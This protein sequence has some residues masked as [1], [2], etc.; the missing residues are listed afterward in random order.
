M[1][2]L[3]LLVLKTSLV[4]GVACAAAS[5]L[6][7]RSAALRHFMLAAGLLCAA[8]IPALQLLTPAWTLPD[9]WSRSH[10]VSSP[11]VALA[12]PVAP[13]SALNEVATASHPPGTSVS[14]T[15]WLVAAWVSGTLVALGVLLAGL[16]RVRRAVTQTVP[17][18]E[19][20]WLEAA[21]RIS[22]RFATRP[23]VLLEGSDPAVLVTH[24]WW[25]PTI[26]LPPGCR[27]WPEDKLRSVLLHELAHVRRRDWVVQ[28]G[29]EVARCV[30]WFNP[31]F[32]LAARRLRQES[33]RACDDAVLREGVDAASYASHLLEIARAVRHARTLP[34]ALGM[35][36]STSLEGRV[37]AMFDERFDRRPV[38]LRA[39]CA[40]VAC[41]LAVAVPIAAG[42]AA[43]D[44]QG[45]RDPRP[46]VTEVGP[47]VLPSPAAAAVTPGVTA[48]STPA[49]PSAPRMEPERT[50][51]T[52]TAAAAGRAAAVQREAPATGSPAFSGIVRG[53]LGA[54]FA[55]V[56]VV[57][58]D[59][60]SG[61]SRTETTGADGRFAFVGIPASRYA[62]SASFPG[63][64]IMRRDVA[65]EDGQP[66]TIELQLRLG[67]S[68]ET[69][70]VPA[71]GAATAANGVPVV[72]TSPPLRTRHCDTNGSNCVTAPLKLVDVRP[73]YPG[74]ALERG[75]RGVVIL[76]TTI[77][78]TGRVINIHVLRGIDPALN[79]AAVE[80]VQQWEFAPM[81]LDD[82]PTSII[83]TVSV[84]FVI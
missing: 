51:K 68:S 83:M 16:R 70:T 12:T 48:P 40:A 30:Y 80:A 28:L 24:G 29:A 19:S 23:V 21:D 15:P 41:M 74:E 61:D 33:E 67:V 69:V 17:L 27:A 26:V 72:R 63:W 1:T 49:G 46:S 47:P 79:S 13:I 6:R 78:S 2:A 84:N 18:T 73:V 82:R 22:S 54:P 81:L 65:I 20:R 55:G 56:A 37:R 8:S 7:R 3:L 45:R 38:T 62:L 43:W 53:A 25:R 64:A 59:P 35:A 5:L 10:A 57:L 4:L 58:T 50:G 44:E 36:Q 77:G 32:W 31:L 52:V 66:T 76:E 75:A 9:T 42:T 14:W 60:A 34:V 11:A 39:A 71:A